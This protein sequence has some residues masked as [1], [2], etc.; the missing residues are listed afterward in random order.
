MSDQFNIYLATYSQILFI[1]IKKLIKIFRGGAYL[2]PDFVTDVLK[3]LFFTSS[4]SSRGKDG[5]ITKDII[6]I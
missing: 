2:G 3:L 1:L 5:C 6:N 4:F